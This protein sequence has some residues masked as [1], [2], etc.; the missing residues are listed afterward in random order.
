LLTAT[1]FGLVNA[2]F[3]KVP[4]AVTA[5]AT[6]SQLSPPSVST[7]AWYLRH[8]VARSA[9]S[10]ARIEVRMSRSEAA[11]GVPPWGRSSLVDTKGFWL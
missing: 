5:A 8:G 6:D 4:A 11:I 10:D 2:R 1:P 3:W 7:I 9:V